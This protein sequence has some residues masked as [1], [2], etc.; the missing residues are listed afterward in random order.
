ME[1]N[2]QELLASYQINFRMNP[3]AAPHFGGAWEREIRS[4]KSALQVVVG[5]QSVPEEVLRTVLIE[6]EGILNSK[7]L[8]YV[9]SDVADIDPVTPNMLLMGRR[10]ASLPQVIYTPEPLS[11]RR[12]RHSQTIV[13]HFWSYYI[14]HYLPSLQTR[15]KWQR[16]TQ[17]LT[18]NMVVMIMD[19]QLPRA[20]WPV[21]RV[22]KLI[23]SA[24]GHIRSAQIKV[25]D[26]LYIRPVA[27]LVRLP[28]LP[29]GG[30]AD[31]KD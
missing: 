1:P 8:G 30:D 3:P 17:D 26:R 27:K 24:D 29:D 23:P 19:P 13:D 25:S 14:R 20:H 18:E 10:D 4:V 6:V 12:W 5:S 16:E 21:G 31:P 15:Q 2:L 7:P 28:A 9:S 11:K 22:V